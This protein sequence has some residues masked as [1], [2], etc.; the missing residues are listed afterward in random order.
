[1]GRIRLRA[2]GTSLQHT[3]SLQRTLRACRKL[4]SYGPGFSFVF[5]ELLHCYDF[6]LITKSGTQKRV[7]YIVQGSKLFIFGVAVNDVK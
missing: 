5:T 4:T 6:N 7:V 3:Y 1:M 2:R